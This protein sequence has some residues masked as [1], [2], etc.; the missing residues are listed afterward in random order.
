MWRLFQGVA[1][2]GIA[3]FVVADSMS[4]PAPFGALIEWLWLRNEVE[5]NAESVAACTIL[6]AGVGIALAPRREHLKMD[7]RELIVGTLAALIACV[8]AGGVRGVFEPEGV[9][10]IAYQSR[11]NRNGAK[12]GGL[13]T[14][15]RG[16]VVWRNFAC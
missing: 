10:H 12:F 1:H 5:H 6:L 9:R 13:S 14:D 11:A 7:G 8:G 2:I 16:I 15:R 3:T 4:D